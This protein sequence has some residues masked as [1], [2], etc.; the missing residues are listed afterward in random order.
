MICLGHENGFGVTEQVWVPQ[1]GCR[2]GEPLAGRYSGG[3]L[4]VSCEHPLLGGSLGFEA[5]SL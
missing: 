1:G 5:G 3:P 2:V 4:W